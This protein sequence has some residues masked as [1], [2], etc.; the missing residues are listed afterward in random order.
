MTKKEL[1]ETKDKLITL[2]EKRKSI[3]EKRNKLLDLKMENEIKYKSIKSEKI[4]KTDFKQLF[5]KDNDNIRESFIQKECK[6]EIKT[7]EKI[8]KELVQNKNELGQIDVEISV[9]R[10]IFNGLIE[11]LKTEE[12]IKKPLEL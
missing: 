1:L 5:G 11:V 4:L 9:H 12:N 10:N 6:N 7:I 2:Y 8:E 3:I